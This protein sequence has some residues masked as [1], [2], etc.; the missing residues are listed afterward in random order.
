MDDLVAEL[1]DVLEDQ[2]SLIQEIRRIGDVGTGQRGAA[3]ENSARF[4]A[5]L[6]AIFEWVDTEGGKY[7]LQLQDRDEREGSEDPR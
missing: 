6:G 3:D 1:I 2:Y 7:G 5:A 4:G